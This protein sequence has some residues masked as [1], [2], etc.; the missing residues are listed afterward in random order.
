MNP[1]P[2]TPHPSEPGDREQQALDWFTRLRASDLSAE[3]RQAF[4]Q[5]RLAPENAQ[6]Y[7]EVE[8]FWQQLELPARRLHKIERRAAPRSWGGWAVAAS[9]LLISGLVMLQ[10]PL[11]Q[12]LNSDVATA[13]GERRQIQLADGSRLT[14][15]SASAVDIDLR[16]PVRKLRLVQ[17]Q[18]F[19][20]VTHDGRP[21]VVDIDDA[22]V[23]VLGTR[24]S[25]SRGRDH[26]EVVL[27]KGKVEVSSAGDKRMLAPGERVTLSGS[28][29]DQVE[30]VDADR[31]L[32]WREG[33]LRVREVPLRQVLEQLA[34]YQ[35]SRLLYIDEQV[36]RRRVSGSFNLDQAGSAIDALA[37]T[38]N[39]NV[40][41]LAGQW[42]I[43]R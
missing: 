31:L 40:S 42:I 9:I 6:T 23:Q 20:E 15:D 5:W 27:L 37:R 39:L 34:E 43:V 26:D 38:Q 14:L 7:A 4:E 36:G 21:F 24:F 18:M 22:Q 1:S 3:E 12:R 28:R 32:A 25:V 35:G 30:K 8:L 11:L 16:G 41:N 10:L 13:V 17:G 2:N 19:I 29:L 33:Q